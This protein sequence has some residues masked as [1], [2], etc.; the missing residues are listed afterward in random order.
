MQFGLS[1]KTGTKLEI[2]TSVYLQAILDR[3]KDIVSLYL[4]SDKNNQQVSY[5]TLRS[6]FRKARDLSGISFQIR[7]LKSKNVTDMENIE[8]A[9]KRLGHSTLR[10]TEHY[11]KRRKGEKVGPLK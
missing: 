10:M 7:D 5:S 2:E 11:T 3:S 4:V 8:L 1:N 6:W 9:K